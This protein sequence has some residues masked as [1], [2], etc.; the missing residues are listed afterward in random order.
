MVAAIALC[1]ALSLG[2][3]DSLVGKIRITGTSVKRVVS[4][5]VN[6]KPIQLRGELLGELGRLGSI[7][8]EVIGQL[9]DDGLAVTRYRIVDIG[10]GVVPMVGTLVATETGLGLNDGKGKPVPLSLPARAKQR[11]MAQIGAKVWVHG[12]SLVSGEIKVRRFGVL[13]D[14]PKIEPPADDVEAGPGQ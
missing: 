6:E 3:P 13:K 4:V 5:V 2:A 10:G 11:L 14:A 1:A 12:K 7:K 9:R 8:V